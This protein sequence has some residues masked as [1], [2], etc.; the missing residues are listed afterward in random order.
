MFLNFSKRLAIVFSMCFIVLI[1]FSTVAFAASSRMTYSG[2]GI[3]DKDSVNNF[4]LSKQTKITV[5]HKTSGFHNTNTERTM[6]VTIS[7]RK[8]GTFLYSATG[9]SFSVNGIR[10][11]SKSWTKDAG[12]Y[13]LHFA[14]YGAYR[15][16]TPTADI[17]GS[18]V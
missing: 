13:K 11:Y 12:T 7:L 15:G 17:S 9:D 5:N 14:T 1:I 10:S 2:T 16:I 18:V 6:G 4:K 3:L 8:K